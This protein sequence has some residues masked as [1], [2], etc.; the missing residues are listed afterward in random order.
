MN[1]QPLRHQADPNLTG[2]VCHSLHDQY[3]IKVQRMDG[4]RWKCLVRLNS[5]QA[6]LKFL[7]NV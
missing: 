7:M 2:Q 4:H 6:C 3:T 1:D 5:N